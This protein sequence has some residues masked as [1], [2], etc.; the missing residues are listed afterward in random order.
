MGQHDTVPCV[1]PCTVQNLCVRNCAYVFFAHR[2]ATGAT[3]SVM[4]TV[5]QR[6]LGRDLARFRERAGLS[7][8]QAAEQLGWSRPKVGRIEAAKTMPKIADVEALLGLYGA[9]SAEAA[10]LVRLAKDAQQRGWWT[11]FNDVFTGSFVGLEDEAAEIRTWET[12]F[13]P[14]LL[15]TEAYAR[16]VISAARPDSP[17]SVHR[18]VQ[19]RMARRTLLG[20]DNAPKLH[21]VI[22]ESVL[23]RAI[24]GPEVM[25]AQF[26][27]LAAMT[28]QPNITLQVLPFAAGAHA[29]LEGPFVLL[30][31]SDPAD[32]DIP[33]IESQGGDV[34][35][36]AADQVARIRLVW[37]RIVAAAASPEESL[38]I[39]TDLTE[40]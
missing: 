3:L 20:R 27:R 19:A 15:Q 8:E 12:Q 14:G 7:Q 39:I 6:R 23:R 36:E 11:A 28:K 25:N 35:L 2:R 5:R 31:F 32:P 40:E 13:V 21:A 33:Y 17:E 24:G 34:Y 4:A 37:E 38:A 30:S 16:A 1:M 26:A 9:D 29:G 10:L 18:R 22:D